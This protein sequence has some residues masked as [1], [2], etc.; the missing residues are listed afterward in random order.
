MFV[1]LLEKAE[2]DEISSGGFSVVF[3]FSSLV[4]SIRRGRRMAVAACGTGV[5]CNR[6]RTSRSLNKSK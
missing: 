2:L 3:F 1:F 4:T 5:K 6:R